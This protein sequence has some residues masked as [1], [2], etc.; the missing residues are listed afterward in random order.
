MAGQ[1]KHAVSEFLH[2]SILDLC[3]TNVSWD[4]N[5]EIDGI[6]CL[7]FGDDKEDHI[8]VKVHEKITSA[9][10]GVSTDT[11]L[12]QARPVLRGRSP[13]SKSSEHRAPIKHAVC[14]RNDDEELSARKVP[15]WQ[16]NKRRLSTAVEGNRGGSASSCSWPSTATAQA[17]NAETTAVEYVKQTDGGVR[18]LYM[19]SNDDTC[20]VSDCASENDDVSV[21]EESRDYC[22]TD[23]ENRETTLNEIKRETSDAADD[24]SVCMNDEF[25][26]S[27]GSSD[28]HLDSATDAY[29]Q[30]MVCQ[31]CQLFVK[32]YRALSEHCTSVHGAHTCL[33]CYQ[34]FVQFADYEA[35]QKTHHTHHNE[36]DKQQQDTS[37]IHTNSKVKSKCG[38]CDRIFWTSASMHQHLSTAHEFDSVF[39]CTLCRTYFP[40]RPTFV[41]HRK[42]THATIEQCHCDACGISFTSVEFQRHIQECSYDVSASFSDVGCYNGGN[43]VQSETGMQNI[44]VKLEPDFSEQVDT[45]HDSIDDETNMEEDGMLHAGGCNEVRSLHTDDGRRNMD[46]SF[47]AANAKDTSTCNPNKVPRTRIKNVSV[48]AGWCQ[49]PFGCGN[50][51]EVFAQ[52]EAYQRHCYLLHSRFACSYCTT[53]FANRRNLQ[54]HA[55]K[56]T[57]E[58][59]YECSECSL[60]FY[61]DDNLRKHKLTHL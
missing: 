57:G 7:T 27:F 17:V 34:S 46:D 14:V 29:P 21:I 58:R 26:V 22:L 61:R 16:E 18:L 13:R 24:F 28:G 25:S 55:R 31:F 10:T 60:R 35:H 43:Y 5:F 59:P 36:F 8:I 52:F 38:I 11:A 4:Q 39:S 15:R 49:G 40:N 42:L 51:S 48:G 47:T 50:C 23:A 54:R 9:V 45:Q 30:E 6:L 2:Q 56:H 33:T 1:R 37:Y 20:T 19:L 12:E 53:S 41:I 32:D 44:E 3:K